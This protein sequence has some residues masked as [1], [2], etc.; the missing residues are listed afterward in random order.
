LTFTD[1]TN[2]AFNPIREA[3]RTNTA[4]TL[5][6]LDTI[7]VVAQCARTEEQRATLL[8]HATMVARGS[9][10]G[11]PEEADRQAVSARYEVVASP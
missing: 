9:S 4:V 11:L 6:L 3:G 10:I 7:M 2:A 5:R 8:R 1:L